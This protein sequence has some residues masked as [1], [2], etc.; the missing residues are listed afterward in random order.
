MSVFLC[1]FCMNIQK[2]FEFDLHMLQHDRPEEN[3]ILPKTVE[4]L[5]ERF[6]YLGIKVLNPL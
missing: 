2:L 4:E 1:P 6:K 3:L 5:D